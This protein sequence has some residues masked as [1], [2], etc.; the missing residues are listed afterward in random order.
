M[1]CI[2]D[3]NVAISSLISRGDSFNVFTLNYLWKKFVFFAPD[4]F[5][6]ELERH[7]TEIIERSKLDRERVEDIINFILSQIT[8]I[9]KSDFNEFLPEAKIIL[10][11]HQKDFPYLALA[12][13]LNC[14]IFSGDKIFKSLCPDKVLN[15]KEMLNKLYFS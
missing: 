7:K 2:V 15:P 10:K 9:D 8:L 6:S 13:K 14:Q 4:F 1:D 11:D 3:V 5:M 12:L